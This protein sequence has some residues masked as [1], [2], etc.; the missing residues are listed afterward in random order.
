MPDI[1]ESLGFKTPE[2]KSALRYGL[3]SAGLG[4]LSNA[5]QPYG[6]SKLAPFGRGGMYGLQAYAGTIEDQRK[7]EKEEAEAQRAMQ[8]L[9]MARANLQYTIGQRQ[10]QQEAVRKFTET[11][12]EDCSAASLPPPARG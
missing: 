4:I 1:F 9:E 7:R 2:E 6:E 3:L 10:A 5:S 8:E 12:P 11:A